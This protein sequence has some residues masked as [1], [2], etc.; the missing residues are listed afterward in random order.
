MHPSIHHTFGYLAL[1]LE[2]PRF[3]LERPHFEVVDGPAHEAH[4]VGARHQP[5]RLVAVGLC[6]GGGGEWGWFR[7]D[8]LYACMYT[9]I[10]ATD[11]EDR[12]SQK[13]K[14]IISMGRS[15]KAAKRCTSTTSAE[16]GSEKKQPSHSARKSGVI[17]HLGCWGPMGW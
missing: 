12:P 11:T 15:K 7:M 9:S 13:K 8:V 5:L 1:E 10:Y 17:G 16:G 6:L 2:G 4:V 3:E 14:R